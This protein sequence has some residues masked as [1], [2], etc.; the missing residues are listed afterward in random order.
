[1][2]VFVS[3]S[4]NTYMIRTI[5]TIRFFLYLAVGIL[6][7]IFNTQL[8]DDIPQLVG[9]MMIIFGLE[10]II[11]EIKLKTIDTE[12][13]RF[14]DNEILIALAIVLFFIGDKDFEVSCTIWAVWSILREG[15]ELA[16]EMHKRK[17]SIASNLSIL[18]SVIVIILSIILI[19]DPIKHARSHIILLGVELILAVIFPTIDYYTSKYKKKKIEKAESAEE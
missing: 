4:K 7:I 17:I 5:L 11:K 10:G 2:M 19:I 12:Y 18:E 1:M 6:I 13:T 14:Y 8:M 16:E 15:R 3:L 9:S